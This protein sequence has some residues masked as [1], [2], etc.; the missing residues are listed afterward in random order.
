MN[1]KCNCKRISTHMVD[2][3]FKDEGKTSQRQVKVAVV[4]DDYDCEIDDDVF[5]TFTKDEVIYGDHGEFIIT[6][7]KEDA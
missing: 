6:Q 2:V 5:Y 3:Y 4:H 7:I 1:N